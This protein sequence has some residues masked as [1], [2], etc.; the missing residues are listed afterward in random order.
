[1]N[2]FEDTSNNTFN[3]ES[4]DVLLN[5]F[6][7]IS[8]KTVIS[9]DKT[10]TVWKE[11][12]GRKKNTYISGWNISEEQMKDHI[13]IIKKKNGCNGSIKSIPNEDEDSDKAS[14]DDDLV[15]VMQLQ[16]DH[17]DYIIDYLIKTGIDEKSIHIKG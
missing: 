8:D 9:K 5:P 3:P 1:M 2:P 16:G 10:I 17:T 7:D 11:S 15:I 14:K 13:K 4:F 12:R 6:E